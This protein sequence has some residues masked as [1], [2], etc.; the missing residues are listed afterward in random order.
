MEKYTIEISTEIGWVTYHTIMRPG[1][2]KATEVLS[3]LQAKFTNAQFRIVKWSGEIILPSY[4][5]N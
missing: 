5:S 4:K 1:Q 2:E 3:E